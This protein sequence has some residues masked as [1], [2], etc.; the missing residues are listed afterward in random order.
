MTRI[1]PQTSSLF[2]TINAGAKLF[3]RAKLN[4]EYYGPGA[5]PRAIVI[6]R[7]FFN[8]QADTLRRAAP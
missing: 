6:E 2:A 4:Q 7:S 3:T 5:T 8:P 1:L